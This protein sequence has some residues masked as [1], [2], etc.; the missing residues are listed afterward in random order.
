MSN[1]TYHMLCLVP[2]SDGCIGDESYPRCRRCQKIG[3][4]CIRGW[5]VK[6]VHGVRTTREAV[7]DLRS[8]HPFEL[9]YVFKADVA[10]GHWE[11]LKVGIYLTQVTTTGCGWARRPQ[12]RT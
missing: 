3:R 12:Q 11:I 9:D 4:E 8:L 7:D 6:F 1:V 2:D 5:N 10:R